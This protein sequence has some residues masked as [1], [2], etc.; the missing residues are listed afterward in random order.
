SFCM[1]FMVSY[2][3]SSN[4]LGEFIFYFVILVKMYMPS[5]AV[6]PR[7]PV[8]GIAPCAPSLRPRLLP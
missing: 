5:T 8:S 3:A 4:Y 6:I 7:G 2:M 1:I